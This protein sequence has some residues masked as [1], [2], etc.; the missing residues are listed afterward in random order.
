MGLL[1]PIVVALVV[2]AG[3]IWLVLR[4]DDQ[5]S[6]ASRAE[7]TV[8]SFLV[9]GTVQFDAACDSAH[10]ETYYDDITEGAQVTVES[11]TGEVVGLATLGKPNDL[12][13]SGPC[14]FTFSIAG[15]KDDG[16][17]YSFNLGRRPP[18]QFNK[19]DAES[20]ALSIDIDS[21]N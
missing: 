16:D 5:S 20:L 8:G 12:G 9:A 18:Y 1:V 15:V 14:E 11:A 10:S 21:A 13:D 7:P 6:G 3:G 4:D 19:S 2:G 17:I